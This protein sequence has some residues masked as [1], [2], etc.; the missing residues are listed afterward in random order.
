MITYIYKCKH[1]SLHKCIVLPNQF[2]SRSH[3]SYDMRNLS[4]FVPYCRT[5]IRRASIKFAGIIT[6]NSVVTKLSSQ[7]MTSIYK[8]KMFITN[9]LHYQLIT[10]QFKSGI[11]TIIN[12]NNTYEV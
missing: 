1:N 10:M 8:L 6:W 12:N 5:N 4:L 11:Q 7:C 9:L 2:T 3:Q